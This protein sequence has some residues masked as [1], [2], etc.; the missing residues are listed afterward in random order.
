V[1]GEMEWDKRRE[2]LAHGIPLPED[3][4]VSVQSAAAAVGIATDWLSK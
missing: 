2:A 4:R 3:V 1:P